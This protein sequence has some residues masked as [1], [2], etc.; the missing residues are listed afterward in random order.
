MIITPRFLDRVTLIIAGII[1][2]ILILLCF[3]CSDTCKTCTEKQTSQIL[4]D[5]DYPKIK[6]Y[7]ACG[8]YLESING[9]SFITMSGK[10]RLTTTINCK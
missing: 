3:A 7:E 5:H 4:T 1:M 10:V 6:T 2:T 9:T 8:D